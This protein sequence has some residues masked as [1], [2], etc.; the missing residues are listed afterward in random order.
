MD[1]FCPQILHRPQPAAA[2]PLHSSGVGRLGIHIDK[3]FA[4][5]HRNQIVPGLPGR[6]FRPLAPNLRSRLQQ[7]PAAS[8]VLHM[9]GLHLTVQLHPGNKPVGPGQE[10]P[11]LHIFVAHSLSPFFTA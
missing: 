7:L 4:L 1:R 11:P 8:G 2:E 9:D 10:P 5:A 6:V 3:P